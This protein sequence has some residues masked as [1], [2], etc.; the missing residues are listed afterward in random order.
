[1]NIKTNLPGN[2]VIFVDNTTKQNTYFNINITLI[3]IITSLF[4]FFLLFKYL[5]EKHFFITTNIPNK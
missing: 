3:A 5:N 1:M 4:L 2:Y